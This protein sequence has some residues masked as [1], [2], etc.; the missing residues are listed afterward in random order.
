MTEILN[1]RAQVWTAWARA[2]DIKPESTAVVYGSFSRPLEYIWARTLIDVVR[3]YQTEG[4]SGNARPWTYAI[5]DAPL[6]QEV[7]D[8]FELERIQ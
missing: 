3:L 5:S 7:V 8:Q 2:Y 1:T 4:R 6:D